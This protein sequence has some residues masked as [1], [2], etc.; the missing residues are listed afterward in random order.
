MSDAVW[1]PGG[2]L[3]D[4]SFFG[5]KNGQL[6]NLYQGDSN[7]LEWLWASNDIIVPDR[8]RLTAIYCEYAG[9][10][11][12]IEVRID[13]DGKQGQWVSFT[14]MRGNKFK[15][16]TFARLQSKF[17]VSIKGVGAPPALYKLEAGLI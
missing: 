14:P 6:Y 1:A 7:D 4:S 13:V 10:P 8:T 9:Q 5:L 3:T 15:L 11:K 17:K 12:T 16:G 2:D